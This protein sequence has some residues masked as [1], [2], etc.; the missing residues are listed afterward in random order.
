V[1]SVEHSEDI[2]LPPKSKFEDLEDLNTDCKVQIVAYQTS[3]KAKKELQILKDKYPEFL[4]NMKAKE[5]G[6]YIIYVIKS[7]IPEGKQKTS[8]LFKESFDIDCK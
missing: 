3:K 7:T 6:K 4:L 1:D 5:N 2:P 8:P